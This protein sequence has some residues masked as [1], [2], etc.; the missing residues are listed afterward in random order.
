MIELIVGIIGMVFILVSFVLDEFWKKFNQDTIIYNLLNIIGSGML[1]YYA[2][3]LKGWP[4][5]ILN[6][7]WLIAAGIKMV[8]ILEKW[9]DIFL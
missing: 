7:V 1:I 6:S 2:L 3:T 8:K 4:F 9:K 5:F